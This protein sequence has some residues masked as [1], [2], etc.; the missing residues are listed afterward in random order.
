MHNKAIGIFDSGVGGLTV[1]K[2]INNLLP[3]E[4][5]IYFGD[6]ARYPYGIRSRN[7][8]IEYCKEISTY[9]TSRQV[10]LIVIA[11]N[12]ASSVALQVLREDI[13]VPII[14][15][16]EAG[17]K[18]AFKRLNGDRIGIIG[19]R[20]TIQSGAYLKAVSAVR[21]DVKIVQ[22]HAPLLVSLIEEGFLNSEITRLAIREYIEDIYQSGVRSL[23]LACTHFPLLK[24]AINEIYPDIDL[25]DTG[26]EIANEVKAELIK[27]NLQHTD[28]ERKG[29]IELYASDITETTENLKNYFFYDKTGSFKLLTLN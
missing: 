15:V 10:K 16:I 21:S 24:E 12:T 18:A 4:D 28:P 2:A 26:V 29:K 8:I 27:R 19:T 13:S 6:T 11:C 1:C 25:I 17:V 22:R 3:N 9:L 5:L 20:A 14:G 23:I 7:T